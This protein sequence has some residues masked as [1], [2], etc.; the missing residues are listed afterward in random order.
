[1]ENVLALNHI[2]QYEAHLERS[3]FTCANE[4]SRVGRPRK[5]VHSANVPPKCRHKLARAAFP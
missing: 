1:M 3:V 4:E 2:A 5:S